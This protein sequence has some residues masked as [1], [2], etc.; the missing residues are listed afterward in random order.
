MNKIT[1]SINLYKNNYSR[2]KSKID[3]IYKTES[4]FKIYLIDKSS[5]YE[6]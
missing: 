5:T 4:Y 1:S 2:I 3:C 6:I